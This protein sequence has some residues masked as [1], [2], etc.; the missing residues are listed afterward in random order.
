MAALEAVIAR[1][2][3]RRAQV[4]IEAIIVEMDITEGQDLGLQWLFSNDS[5]FYGSNISSS[6]AQ[7]QRNSAIA[8][9]LVPDDGSENIGTRAVAGALSQIPGATLGWGVLTNR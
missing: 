6:T 9:A 3:I 8:N 7:L 2:D 4:L 5:G 1:L